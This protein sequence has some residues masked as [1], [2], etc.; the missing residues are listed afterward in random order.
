VE[1]IPSMSEI[2]EKRE[3]DERSSEISKIKKLKLI[4]MIIASKWKSESNLKKYL[5]F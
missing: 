4:N 2:E 1:K 3:G 5:N